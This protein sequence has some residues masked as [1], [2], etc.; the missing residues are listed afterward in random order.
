MR[1]DII[2]IGAGAAGLA[3]AGELARR[4][5]RVAVLEARDRTGG[6]ILTADRDGWPHPVELGAEFIH[7]GNRS[8]RKLLKEAKIG[9]HPVETNMWWHENG[10][11]QLV[12]D[13]WERI[14]R[15]TA[16]IPR[17]DH[18][19]SF[20]H[21]L[22]TQRHHLDPGDRRLADLFVGGYSAGST[23]RISAR[24]QRAGHAGA[25]STDLKIDGR[26]DAVVR[27]LQRRCPRGRVTLHLQSV[28]TGI[29]WKHGAVTVWTRLP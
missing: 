17:R 13:Y 15:V 10:R 23:A 6:R 8:L 20:Q 2:V 1:A 19:W 14:R 21:F 4:G 22:R 18:G 16:R 26:Y 11:L 5:W 3:A 12:P 25:D 24:A 29:R 7:G 27:G 28:V 9:T